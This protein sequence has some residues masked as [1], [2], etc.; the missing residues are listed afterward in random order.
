LLVAGPLTDAAGLKATFLVLA[1]P[2]MLIG[3][4]ACRLP[5]LH[6]LDRAPEFA[7]DPGP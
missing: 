3:L 7:Q 2:I 1:V 6:E 5:S 4:V